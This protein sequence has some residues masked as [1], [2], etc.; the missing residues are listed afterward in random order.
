MITA[1]SVFLDS[2]SVHS[3]SHFQLS[4]NGEEII[5]SKWVYESMTDFHEVL[6]K[7]FHADN[8]IYTEKRLGM[9]CLDQIKQLLGVVLVPVTKME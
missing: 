3:F 7:L 5:A 1:V 4:A 9:K 6:V 2:V 8:G